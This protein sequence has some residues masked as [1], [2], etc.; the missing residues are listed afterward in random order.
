MRGWTV[1]ARTPTSSLPCAAE[2]VKVWLLRDGRLRV[3]LNTGAFA[4]SGAVRPAL[5]AAAGVHYVADA[6][7]PQGTWFQVR[8]PIQLVLDVTAGVEE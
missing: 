5:L 6:S 8:Q 1:L 3:E 7:A 4:L 2:G